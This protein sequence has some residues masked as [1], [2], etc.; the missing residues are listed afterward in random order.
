MCSRK[1]DRSWAH[2]APVKIH[3]AGKYAIRILNDDTKMFF[4]RN[5]RCARKVYNLYVDFLY[6]KLEQSGYKEEEN[7]NK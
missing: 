6:E 2:K 5:F 4:I 3:G 1:E 7:T